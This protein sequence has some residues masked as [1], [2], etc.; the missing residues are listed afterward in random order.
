[1]YALRGVDYADVTHNVRYYPSTA[2]VFLW[3]PL[4]CRHD[5]RPFSSSSGLHSGSSQSLATQNR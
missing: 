4:S 2:P 3:P 1:M 5:S